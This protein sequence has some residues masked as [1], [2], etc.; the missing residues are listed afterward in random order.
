MSLGQSVHYEI[1]G[2]RGNNW[3][4]LEVIPD[5]KNAVAAAEQLWGSRKYQGVRVVKESYDKATNEFASIE[6]Y[7]RGANRKTSKYDQSGTISPCLTPDDL[8][9]TAGRRSIWE[10]LHNTLADWMITPTELLH[11]LD[12]YYKLYNAGTKLQNAVQRTAVAF[13]NEQ[14]SIQERMRK[15]QKVIDTALE[16]M[17]QNQPKVP[18]LEM[19]RLK[20]VIADMGEIKNRRFLLT[21]AIAD[22]L[23]PAVTL[24]DK[25]GRIVAFLSAERPTWVL[26][27]LDQFLSELLMHEGVLVQLM[28]DKEQRDVF[29]EEVAH[30]QVGQVNMMGETERSPRFSDEVLRLNGFLSEGLLPQTARVLYDRLKT[31]IE[32]AKPINDRGLVEQLRALNRLLQALDALHKDSAD[33]DTMYEALASR[34]GRLINSQVVGEMLYELKNPVDQVNALLDLEQVTI[35]M[36]NKRMV[37]NFIL[38]ILSRPEYESVFMG[39]DSHPIKRMNDL[40]KLQARVYEADLTEM[41]KRKIAERLDLFC[42]TILDNTQVLKKIHAMNISLQDKAKKILSMMADGYFTEGDCLNRAE[43]QVRVYMKQ[44]GFT[45]GLIAGADRGQAEKILLD[46]KQ[47]LERSGFVKVPEPTPATSEE[48]DVSSEGANADEAA[49]EGDEGDTPDADEDQASEPSPEAPQE[50]AKD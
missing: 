22:Y 8:Y 42:R 35:G 5:R 16:I 26:E 39:L 34:A 32:A 47:L 14:D 6:I 46:F 27:I 50:Q 41:H 44:P 19:G 11:N 48:E 2:R 17:K 49:P 12:H 30:L 10:L 37:A 38:P 21:A 36:A 20:P 43:H 13:E 18:S 15:I 28:G 24:G 3:R 23:K 9:T 33:V 29:M 40:V 4:I 7:S 31:E 1:L 25:F 45:S